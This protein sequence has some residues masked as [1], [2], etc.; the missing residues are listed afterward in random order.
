MEEKLLINLRLM[1]VNLLYLPE[2]INLRINIFDL[3]FFFY[4]FCD[5]LVLEIGMIYYLYDIPNIFLKINF[6]VRINVNCTL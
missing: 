4:K 5:A 6:R 2:A 1:L 3:L